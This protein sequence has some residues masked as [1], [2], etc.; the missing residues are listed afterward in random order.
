[1]QISM[2]TST[3]LAMLAFIAGTGDALATH[4]NHLDAFS[5][6]LPG[7]QA[8]GAWGA[9]INSGSGTLAAG[10]YLYA[11][12]ALDAG[13]ALGTGPCPA[14]QVVVAPAVHNAVAFQWPATP[15]ATGCR[16]YRRLVGVTPAL[17]ALVIA[18]GPVT[19][20]PAANAGCAAGGRCLFLDQGAAV[21]APETA[22]PVGVATDGGST[23]DVRI[24]QRVDY[25]GADPNTAAEIAGDDPFPSALKTD[26]IEFPPGLAIDAGATRNAGNPVRC[27]LTGANSLLG[28]TTVFGGDDVNEDTCPRATL[29]GSVQAWLRTL[30]GIQ[31]IPGEIYNGQAKGSEP[32][33]LFVVLRPQCSVGSIFAPGSATCTAQ[34]GGS[35]RQIEKLFLAAVISPVARGGGITAPDGNLVNA[36][37]DAPVPEKLNVLAPSGAR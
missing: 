35:N 33:R 34:L 17:E 14:I 22:T 26:T 28:S 25:G 3:T 7:C 21:N 30:G 32:L 24:L 16:I 18:A 27:P 5:A 1:M 4:T 11:I 23:A 8:R 13:G 20:L 6:N 29:V 10:T 2:F 15:G 31:S 9:A 19:L 37:D 36:E 12:E